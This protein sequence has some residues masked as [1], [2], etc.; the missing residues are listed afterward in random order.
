MKKH[1]VLI[2]TASILFVLAFGAVAAE[3][4]KLFY[5]DYSVSYASLLAP[6]TLERNDT[7]AYDTA[8]FSAKL[9]VDI[10]KWADVYVGGDFIFFVDRPDMQKHYTFFPYYAGIRANLFPEWIVFPGVFAEVGGAVCNRHTN[11]IKPPSTFPTA[12]DHSWNGT[13]FN[14]GFDINL[15]VTDIAVLALRFERPTISNINT[16]QDELHI[17]K[18]GIAWKVLY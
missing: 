9:G 13:Y 4:P 16:P 6:S 1:K 2:F 3:I 11:S 10:L 15:N 5:T 18:A 14:F 8:D 12:D 17:I 7:G